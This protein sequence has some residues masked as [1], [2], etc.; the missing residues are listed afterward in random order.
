MSRPESLRRNRWKLAPAVP[1]DIG[2]DL[3]YFN[4]ILLQ[5]L[6][7]RGL[8]DA[9]QIKAFLQGGFLESRDPF[10]LTDMDKAVARIKKAIEEDEMVIVYGDFDADGITSTV[11][12]VE[13]LRGLGMERRQAQ[14]YIP[15]RVDEG[16]GL[17]K[18]ALTSIRE[19]GATL[20]ITVD[21]GVRAIGAV[22]HANE[23]GLDVIV[24]D[25]HSLG[26]E[27]PPAVAIVNP[28]RPESA[29]PEKMLAGVGIAFK[30]AQ[31]L[32]QALPDRATFEEESLLDLVALGTV[33]DLAPLLGENRKL[34]TDGLEVLNRC[35]RPGIE[36]LA[37]V[38]GLN[39]GEMTAESISFNLA[40]RINAAGRLTHAYEAAR[41]LAVNNAIMA[42][43]YAHHLNSLNQERQ[44]MTATLVHQAE[45][46]IDP[47]APLLL[48]ADPDFMSGVV[49]LVASR[50]AEKF[51]RPAIVLEKGEDTSRGSCR[52]IDPFSIVKA[53]DQLE[54][55]LVR[56]GGHDMAA[57]FTIRNENL[58]EFHERI[59]EIAAS[60]LDS[61]DLM[62]TLN[63]DA[64]INVTEV[65]WALQGVLEQ[66]EPTGA[67]N[68]KPLFI[69][70]NVRVFGHR[71][72]GRDNSHLQLW[73]GDE[74]TK[75]QGIAFRQGP[76]ALHL[77]DH[78]DLAYTVSVNEWKG[79]RNLQLMVKDIQETG[80]S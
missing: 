16:Y 32:R 11:L 34:V 67:K 46:M 33:A 78:V 53:L 59:I 14:P 70:R 45:H 50:L 76:W 75:L 39:P 9:S 44:K 2:Q 57:G 31:A 35:R 37:N 7:N 25:H 1:S 22:Q 48:A 66:L 26:E 24:T 29:Y 36:A 20:V 73:V 77:S 54:S 42:K 71:V 51:Y 56:H 72:V 52:S 65:D 58:E 69:S 3:I 41:L 21:C 61:D 47:D 5:V 64:E 28:K 18:D 15:D 74:R 49:G 63:I 62:P 10:L 19:K 60:Q 68:R 8:K 79:K 17:N 13:A 38:S 4:P 27:L 55:L 23:I 43:E 40:P 12:L 30:L 6:H 80:E